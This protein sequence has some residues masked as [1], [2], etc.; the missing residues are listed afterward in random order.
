MI[1]MA[2]ATNSPTRHPD[3]PAETKCGGGSRVRTH[4]SV[5]DGRGD[6][7]CCEDVERVSAVA[8]RDASEAL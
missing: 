6:A 7:D 4:K 3:A 5:T 8:G 1:V 2:V